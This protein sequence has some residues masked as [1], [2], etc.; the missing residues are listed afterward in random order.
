[1]NIRTVFKKSLKNIFPASVQKMGLVESAKSE[2][3]AAL[4]TGLFGAS[5]DDVAGI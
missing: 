4:L 3:L 2:H 5:D 1:V